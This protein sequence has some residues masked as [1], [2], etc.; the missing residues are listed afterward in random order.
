[1]LA[2]LDIEHEMERQ[3]QEKKALSAAEAERVNSS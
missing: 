2:S 1:M 3:Q